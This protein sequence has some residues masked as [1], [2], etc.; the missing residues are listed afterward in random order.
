MGN[1]NSYQKDGEI[2]V[3]VSTVLGVESA[4]DLVKWALNK[5]G[6]DT[7]QPVRDYQDWMTGVAE[8]GTLI[9]K[10]VEYD[11]K[12]MQFPTHEYTEKMIPVAELYYDWKLANG[13]KVVASEIQVYSE[14]YRIA[15]TADMVAEVNGKLYVIDIK[16]GSIRDKMFT[17]LAAYKSFMCEEP[18][19]TRIKGIEEAG[20]AILNIHRDGEKQIEFL[21]LEDYYKDHDVTYKDHVGVFHALR[22]IWYVRNVKSRKWAAVIKNMQ[23]LISPMEKRFKAKFKI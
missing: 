19:R 4:G 12:G 13:L 15:G 7:S 6:K 21:T 3:S 14:K 18:K 16:T 5:F 20:L 8:E 1:Y 23:D 17:Q 2:Y 11:V 10:F 22:Y 9:H